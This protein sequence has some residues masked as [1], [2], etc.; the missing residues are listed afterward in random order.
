MGTSISN[1]LIVCKDAQKM[2]S[3][4]K[5]KPNRQVARSRRRLQKALIGLLKKKPYQ[6]ITISKISR[7]A[8]LARRTFYEH[9][10]S[11]DDL[12]LSVVDDAVE[13]F[14][15]DL[16][17]RI[18]AAP[19]FKEDGAHAYIS[20]FQHWKEKGE[21]LALVRKTNCDIYILK[22]L[23]EWFYKLYLEAVVPKDRDLDRTL[24]DYTVSMLA[25]ATF[26]FL[27]HWADSGMRQTPEMMGNFLYSII[28]PPRIEAAYKTFRG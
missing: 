20:L 17:G 11:K 24:D 22:R 4:K 18:M 28:G 14:F 15:A 21:I 19:L 8:D 1:N 6:K 25:G 3:V 27:T 12:L 9:F 7:R 13:P 16:A 2:E 10:E 23:R 5:R 26:M